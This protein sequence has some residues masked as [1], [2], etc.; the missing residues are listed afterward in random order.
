MTET[1]DDVAIGRYEYIRYEDPAAAFRPYDARC[2]AVAGRVANLIRGRMPEARV[3]HVGSTAAPGCAGKGVVDLMLLYPP[4]R[5]ADARDVLD[6]LGFQRHTGPN[7][8]PEERPVRIGTQRYDGATLRLHVHVISVDSPEAAA[9]V[10]FRDTSRSDPALV[11]A[12][13]ERKRAVLAAGA[14][15]G[16][17]YNQGKEA[18]IHAALSLDGRSYS[19]RGRFG[20]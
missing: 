8:F 6:G 4:G 18:F 19:N 5:L 10:R 14:A 2:P 16:R 17:A 9:Q 1:S 11:A 20:G 3:E 13:V 7:A 12:Y 15:D